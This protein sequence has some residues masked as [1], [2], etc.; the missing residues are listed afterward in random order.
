MDYFQVALVADVACSS[1]KVMAEQG[2]TDY[3]LATR[4]RLE[5]SALLGSRCFPLPKPRH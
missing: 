3:L 1:M 5:V 4:E 2:V